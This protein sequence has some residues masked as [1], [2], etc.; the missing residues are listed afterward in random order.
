M[1]GLRAWGGAAVHQQSCSQMRLFPLDT[2]LHVRVHRICGIDV[3]ASNQ[4]GRR[5]WRV[6]GAVARSLPRCIILTRIYIRYI[7]CL[8]QMTCTARTC[9]WSQISYDRVSKPVL[10]LLLCHGNTV[11]C[12]GVLVVYGN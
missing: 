5:G 3:Q 11:A 9:V 10:V 8:H 1:A 2:H 4:V 6:P 7:K 12:A